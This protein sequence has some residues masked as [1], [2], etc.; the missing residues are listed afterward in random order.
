MGVKQSEGG[1]L[2]NVSGKWKG[3][4]QLGLYQ[5]ACLKHLEGIVEL[6]SFLGKFLANDQ[7]KLLSFHKSPD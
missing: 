7:G 3:P 5:I 2:K 6:S 1:K 4:K